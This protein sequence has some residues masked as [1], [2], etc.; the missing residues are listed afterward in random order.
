MTHMSQSEIDAAIQNAHHFF[1]LNEYDKSIEIYQ[2]ILSHALEKYNFH[3][4]I[5]ICYSK[6]N[7]FDHALHHGFLFL[8]KEP[9]N[10]FAI[11]HI[12]NL[13]CVMNKKTEAIKFIKSNLEIITNNFGIINTFFNLVDE[14]EDFK[15]ILTITDKCIIKEHDINTLN[16]IKSYSFYKLKQSEDASRYLHLIEIDNN[17][18]YNLLLK[19]LELTLYLNE[20][21]SAFNI[22]NSILTNNT[23]QLKTI[24]SIIH[25]SFDTLNINQSIIKLCD[26]LISDSDNF[27][28]YYILAYAFIQKGEREIC[29]QN[30]LKFIE[31]APIPL[32]SYKLV[33]NEYIE[34]NQFLIARAIA[35]DAIAKKIKDDQLFYLY[36][37]L[38]STCGEFQLALEYINK[39]IKIN[40]MAIEYYLKVASIQLNNTEYKQALKYINK[41]LKISKSAANLNFKGIIYQ[42]LGDIYKAIKFFKLAIKTNALFAGAYQNLAVCYGFLGQFD[43]SDHFSKEA[44]R[45]SQSTGIVSAYLMSLHY[46]P[47]LSREFILNEHLNYAHLFKFTPPGNINSYRINKDKTNK[48]NLGFISSGFHQHPV[49]AMITPILEHINK[50]QFTLNFYCNT[51]RYDYITERLKNISDNWYFINTISDENLYKLIQFDEIDILFELSGHA[52]G[53]KL[54]VMT[55]KPAPIIIK[56]VGGLFN[57]TGLDCFDYLISDQIETPDGVDKYYVEKL[58]RMP[59]DYICY[60]PPKHTPKIDKIPYEKNGFITFGCFNNPNKINEPL[61]I[62]WAQI[63]NAVPKSKLFLKSSQYGFDDYNQ[64]IIKIMKKN[65]IDEN[66]LIFEGASPHYKLLD[67]YNRVDIA[68]DPWPYSGGLTTCEALL[69]GVPVI[70]YPG[71]TFAGRHSATHLYNAGLP[72]FICSDWDEYHTQAINLASNIDQLRHFRSNLREQILHSSMCD[73]K[74][75]SQNLEYELKNIYSNYSNKLQLQNINSVAH[76]NIPKFN[77][78]IHFLDSTTY[79]SENLIRDHVIMC[80]PSI[81]I[82]KAHAAAEQMASR[83]GRSGLSII[84]Y[85]DK[86]RDGFISVTN[87]IY[88]STQSFLFGYVAEDAFAGRNWL[89]IATDSLFEN[90]SK[91][92]AFN[93]GKWEGKLAG[94]G[95]ALRGWTEFYNNSNFFYSGYNSHYADTELSIIASCRNELTTN[96]RSLLIEVDAKKETKSVN[97]FD[98]N[99]FAHRKQNKFYL[100]EGYLNNLKKLNIFS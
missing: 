37:D 44:I 45:L 84:I 25:K 74:L 62:R 4:D 2:N 38:L 72:E 91:L 68:L 88:K 65:N 85:D 71:P 70:T 24:C 66:R 15:E 54:N 13:Y 59:N 100:P 57:T 94:F 82:E 26:I 80:M 18:E 93:D 36:G 33:I 8:E 14:T 3:L 96:L 34:K 21:Q 22:I 23:N 95:L 77:T 28:A 30:L 5:S 10:I 98:Q 51:T 11:E 19:L 52:E 41:A 29:E 87:K 7:M 20:Y 99:L 39:A 49:G 35:E 86:N 92:F 56:W 50:D 58:I 55:A 89:K 32:E 6:L 17:T 64:R 83:A 16:I 48:I 78:K 61:L 53:N 46:N 67:S 73:G 1:N 12:I 31:K 76:F 27:I 9:K 42:R 63:L 43:K 75:Y 69:M 97:I 47:A 40:K 60:M 79:I 90:N 81:D